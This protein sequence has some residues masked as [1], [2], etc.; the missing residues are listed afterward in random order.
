MNNRGGTNTKATIS[1]V[2]GIVSLIFDITFI[3]GIIAIVLGI[4]AKNEIKYS[5]EEGD[6]FATAGIITGILGIVGHLIFWILMLVFGISFFSIF[7]FIF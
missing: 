5:N 2:L 6:G 3:V 4:M 7:N 1:M